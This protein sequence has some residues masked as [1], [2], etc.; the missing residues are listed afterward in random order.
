MKNDRPIS[1][2]NKTEKHDKSPINEKRC[3]RNPGK[4]SGQK[5]PKI[6]Y[7]SECVGSR[8]KWIFNIFDIVYTPMTSKFNSNSGGQ[9]VQLYFVSYAVFGTILFANFFPFT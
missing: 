5:S 6:L 8:L 2:K 4:K 3:N 9:M 7:I 1:N